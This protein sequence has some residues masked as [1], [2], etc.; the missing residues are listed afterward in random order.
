MINVIDTY[1]IIKNIDFNKAYEE[2]EIFNKESQNWV[3]SNNYN[4]YILSPTFSIMDKLT[5]LVEYKLEIIE[6]TEG[7]DNNYEK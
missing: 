4:K 1:L 3:D 6:V 7:D 5:G 2:I